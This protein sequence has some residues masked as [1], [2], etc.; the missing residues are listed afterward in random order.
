VGCDSEGG[1]EDGGGNE[2][3]GTEEDGTALLRPGPDPG[4]EVAVE[5]GGRVRREGATVFG[6]GSGGGAALAAAVEVE[7][8][9]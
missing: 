9:A 8:G 6:G 1:K 3:G 2:E 7:E 4:A 5:M